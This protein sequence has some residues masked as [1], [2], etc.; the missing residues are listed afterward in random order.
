MRVR[1]LPASAVLGLVAVAL[2]AAAAGPPPAPAGGPPRG[3]AAAPP[4]ATRPAAGVTRVTVH[5]E[6]TGR[7]VFRDLADQAGVTLDWLGGPADGGP[8]RRFD[9]ER[10][11]FWPA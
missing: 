10:E 2:V 3:A 11:P 5:R 6:G 9:A 8:R 7:E 4:P 1:V